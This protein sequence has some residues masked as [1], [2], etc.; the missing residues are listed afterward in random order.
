MGKTSLLN[1]YT[2]N[3]FNI[4]TKATIGVEYKK[5]TLKIDENTVTSMIWDTAG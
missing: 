3:V 4:D 5:K 2:E 1:R